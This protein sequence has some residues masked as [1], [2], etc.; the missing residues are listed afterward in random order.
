MKR[1][2][3]KRLQQYLKNENATYAGDKEIVRLKRAYRKSYQKRWAR[4]YRKSRNE[5]RFLL[6]KEQYTL[7]KQ[8]CIHQTTP[9]QLAKELLI[10]HGLS[11]EY[12]PRKEEL[13]IVLRDVGLLI[14]QLYRGKE[15]DSVKVPL[16]QIE[17]NLIH[18]L[19]ET[20][21]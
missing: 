18:Y 15:I 5:I 8:K 20:K 4:E 16:E 3:S 6:S 14:N 1:S 12:I 7:V 17:I 11:Q 2:R 10:G 21:S 9:T 13:Q 19:N